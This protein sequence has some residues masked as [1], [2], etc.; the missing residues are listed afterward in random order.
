MTRR[1][2]LSQ[3]IV[4]EC[5][6]GGLVICRHNKIKGELVAL[7]AKAFTPSAICDELRIHPGRSAPAINAPAVVPNPIIR[8]TCH[9]QEAD[10]CDILIPGLWQRGTDYILDIRVTDVDAKSNQN[11]TPAK[12]LDRHKKEKKR[13]Y[14]QA[15]MDQCQ[16]PALHPFCGLHRRTTG[17]RSGFCIEEALSPTIREMGLA[18]LCSLWLC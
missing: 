14:L 6:K 2:Q 9:S 11:K 8:L 1:L 13:K 15:C 18:I 10:R 16:M 4:L 5:K 3:P 17:Q 12:V 7:T